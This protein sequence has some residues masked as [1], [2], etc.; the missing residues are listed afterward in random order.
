MLTHEALLKYVPLAKKIASSFKS[1][2]REEAL[3]EALL[4]LCI[5]ADRFDEREFKYFGPL[6]RVVITN[7]L[8]KLYNQKKSST[9]VFNVDLQLVEFQAQEDTYQDFGVKVEPMALADPH[10]PFTMLD[11]V[12]VF[13]EWYSTLTEE[14]QI[15]IDLA[16]AHAN[17]KQIAKVVGSSQPTVQR[18]LRDMQAS[19]VSFLHKEKYAYRYS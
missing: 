9:H 15:I 13:K 10:D 7:R 6:A 4:G 18:R 12:E 5:A 17:Q 8:L 1:L 16:M 3:G 2:D 14:Q 19:L 11:L